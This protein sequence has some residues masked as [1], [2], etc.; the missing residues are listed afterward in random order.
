MIMVYGAPGCSDCV[1][2]ARFLEEHGVDY[3]YIDLDASPE[4]LPDVTARNDGRRIIPTII[5]EDGSHLAEPSDEELAAKLG[6]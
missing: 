6:Y 4:F 3:E 2:S 5:F 1:R